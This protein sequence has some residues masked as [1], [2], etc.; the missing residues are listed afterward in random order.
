[1]A[2]GE[3]GALVHGAGVARGLCEVQ[4]LRLLSGP[5]PGRVR[6]RAKL[7]VWEIMSRQ[8][9]FTSRSCL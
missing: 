9:R 4:R 3:F 7:E 8:A 6:S 2:G 1:M 5:P